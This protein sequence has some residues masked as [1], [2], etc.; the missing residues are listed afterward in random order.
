VPISGSTADATPRA[1]RLV[2]IVGE[3]ATVLADDDAAA[4]WETHAATVRRR[5]DDRAVFRF[6]VTPSELT[7]VLDA[8][9]SATPLTDVTASPRTG[10]ATVALPADPDVVAEAH[11]YVAAAGG[12]STLRQRPPGA[13]LPAFGPAPTSAA[14][15]RAVAT[16]LDPDQRLGRG[17][18]A[19]W[20]PA[21]QP[22]GVTA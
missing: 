19:P 16:S 4:A 9:G 1:E 18:L 7:E 15:L 11:R 8:L 21:P 3:G 12:T 13:M 22:T 17:R 2:G 6:G 5:A 14:L 20:I 10:V